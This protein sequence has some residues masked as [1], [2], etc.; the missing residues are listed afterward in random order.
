[1]AFWILVFISRHGSLATHLELI[2]VDP[3]TTPVGER[4]SMDYYYP[5]PLLVVMA[6][7]V[8]CSSITDVF[9]ALGYAERSTF[10]YFK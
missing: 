8:Q 7:R 10:D 5:T 9:R 2:S 3:D 1:V 4:E 6:D